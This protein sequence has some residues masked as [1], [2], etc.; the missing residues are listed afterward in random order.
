MF[1]FQY[2]FV[3]NALIAGLG[4]AIIG[5]ILGPFLVLRKMSLLGDGIAH[6]AFGAAALGLFLGMYPITM[7]IPLSVLGGLL[8]V[9]I[10]KRSAVYADS[11]IGIVSAFGIASGVIFANSTQGLTVN[12]AQYLFGNILTVSISEIAIIALLAMVT[13]WLVHR[14]YRAY[15][16]STFDEEY[17]R[18]LGTP[19]TLVQSS[20]VALTA[21]TIAVSIS[22]VGAFLISSLLIIPAITA[23]QWRL[24]FSKTLW[25]SVGCAVSAMIVGII[26]SLIFD[27]PTGATIVLT[28]VAMYIITLVLKRSH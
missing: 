15:F 9:Q 13:I 28:N 1:L 6:V 5:G 27:Y 14:Y 12:V 20:L 2:A 10:N 22:I 24:S 25:L 18:T 7:T 11:A 16:A 17:A 8:I 19:V 23:L 26:V 4:I 3:Q 21:L